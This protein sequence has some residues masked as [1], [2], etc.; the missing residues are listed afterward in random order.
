MARDVEIA[1][2]FYGAVFGWQYKPGPQGSGRYVFALAQGV[3]VAGLGEAAR[4]WGLPV[5]WSVY[6]A[7]D[8]ADR[9]ADRV[10]ERSATV[11][12]GPIK[13][14]NGRLVFA[15]DPDDALFSIWEGAAEPDWRMG[16]LCG[17][18]LRVQ[19]CT[20]DPF[21][22]ALFYGGVFEWDAQGERI[23]IRYEHDHVVLWVDGYP[24]AALY[25]GGIETAPDPHVRPQW[26]VHFCV[27]DPED[28][29]AKVVASGGTVVSPPSLSPFGAPAA[30]FRDRQ[31]GLFH[32][33]GRT[34]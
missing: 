16:H 6:F 26:H 8:S 29:A 13:F 18:P 5:A 21:A 2:D 28:T 30:T 32:V 3:P 7:A 10:R 14:R 25:G 19:L 27:E 12:V 15:A 24:A 34:P 20:R 11:A 9:A 1:Q 4:A 33:E 22:A 31:G 17:A 23:D